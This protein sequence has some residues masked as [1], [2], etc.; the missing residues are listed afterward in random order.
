MTYDLVVIG[1]GAAGFFGAIRYA[2]RHPQNRVLILEKGTR[3]LDKVR[4]SGGGR[5]NVTHAC[6]DPKELVEFYPRGKKEM[7]GPFTRFACG[8]MMAWL[9]ERH[10]PTHIEEDGRVFPESN[11]SASIINVFAEN[12]RLLGIE[13]KIQEGV[14]DLLREEG[15]WDVQSSQHNYKTR[16]LLVAAGGTPSVWKLLEKLDIPIIPPVP[17]LFTFKINHPLLKDMAGTSV[18]DGSVIIRDE[19]LEAEGPI[20]ITHWGLSGPG[21]LKI[22]AWGARA[23]NA[24]SYHF[25]A[26]VN[27]LNL[28]KSD[29]LDWIDGVRLGSGSSKC[30]NSSPQG[31]TKR[32]WQRMVEWLG[33]SELNWADLNQK[34]I[35]SLTD[36]LCACKFEVNGKSTHKE[37][38]V[39]SGGVRLD[40]VNFKTMEVKQ[41]PN[42][43]LAGEVLDIDALTGGFNFQAAWTTSWI[44]AESMD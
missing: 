30:S 7:L 37:E 33:L 16:Q 15:S 1:G 31:I 23:L 19:K 26:E 29:V 25:T 34:Q 22:S 17:S 42:L 8:D 36:C 13:V 40:A 28:D 18:P 41:H 38:F 10:V 20:L 6:F 5:C 11:Q 24:K 21:I 32:F 4:V 14:V 12:A 3:I 9:D 27:W 44:A 39:T 2:E 43:Y 35:E